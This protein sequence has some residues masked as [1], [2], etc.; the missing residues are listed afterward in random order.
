MNPR[1]RLLAVAIL[2]AV[3]LAG[4]AFLFHT[5]FLGPMHDRSTMI[6]DLLQDIGQKQDR[7][8]QVTALEPK[9][10]RWKL[11][12]L[13]KDEYLARR[14]YEVYLNDLLSKSGFA[15]GSWTVTSQQP[16]SKTTPKIKGKGPIYTQL[17]FTVLTHGTLKNLVDFLQAF[18]RTG[19]LNRIKVL[20]IRRPLTGGNQAETRE[21]DATL[22]IE[23]L[24]VTGVENRPT[25]QP[26]MDPRLVWIE[27]VTALRRAPLSGLALVP[28]AVGPTGPLGPGDLAEQARNYASITGKDIFF[29]PPATEPRQ[30]EVQVT[31]FVHLTDITQTDK[32][33]E[34][35][36][37]D[38]LNNKK[39]RLRAET[40][41]DSFR[42]EDGEGE[43]VLH[44]KVV[45]IDARDLVFK[46]DDK[47]YNLHIGES[48]ADTLKH[49]LKGREL[50]A[51]GVVEA[52]PAKDARR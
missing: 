20:A 45:K 22:T 49:P 11:L 44:G 8:R 18:Y 51:F 25:L 46:A 16:D 35:F 47:Y 34:A 10:Q 43:T 50:R 30:E 6:L 27:A 39:T 31:S 19:L 36:L 42:V 9:L 28:W 15:P 3:V 2:V 40:G 24:I 7:V 38:R 14:D 37:Y 41:F 29:G 4:G 12:S 21:L 17:S 1:E 33:N 13:P 5:L 32:R 48:L 26:G 23:A 52:E